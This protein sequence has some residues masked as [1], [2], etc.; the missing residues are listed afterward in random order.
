[1][2]AL[3]AVRSLGLSS[4]CIGAGVIRSLV[5]D[6]LHGFQEPSPVADIDVAYF[7]AGASL[8]LDARLGNQLSSLLGGLDW[9][10]TNQ[11]RVHEWLVNASGQAFP[12]LIS[13]EDGLATW[14]EFATCV[15]VY[16]DAYDSLKV[17][18][19]YGLDDLFELRIRHN[20]RR[21]SVA[22]FMD[23]VRSKRFDK[24]WPGVTI[25]SP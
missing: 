1:M 16:L 20:P 10:V 7:D 17:I 22:T 19:P 18:A 25:C 6:S 23:R 5:W 15:G 11:A 14:P 4:W 8:E 12:P 2:A 24:R 13:L 21:V 9:E 3:R